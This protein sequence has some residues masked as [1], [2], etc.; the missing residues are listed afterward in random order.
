[1]LFKSQ[2]IQNTTEELK[3]NSVKSERGLGL[4]LRKDSLNVKHR[5][6]ACDSDLISMHR[7]ILIIWRLIG[8]SLGN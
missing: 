1:M 3:P 8:F 5:C 2:S 6:S 4:F 7:I